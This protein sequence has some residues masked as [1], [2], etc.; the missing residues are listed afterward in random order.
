MPIVQFEWIQALKN[1]SNTQEKLIV[2]TLV[3]IM[4]A[5]VI[6]F[7]S[8]TLAAKINPDIQFRSKEGI[9]GILRK[10]A[11]IALLAYCIP[12][13]VLLPEG[14]GLGALQI[15]YTGYLFFELKSIL[16]NYEKLKFDTTLLREFVSKL[17]KNK[18]ED[19]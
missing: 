15:L 17:F 1:A 7:L 18:G 5:M 2:Y 13:S 9:N 11:S 12:L 8:G 3:L 19:K 16:E 4:I 10:I 14:V 6:D